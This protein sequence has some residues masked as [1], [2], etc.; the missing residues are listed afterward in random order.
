MFIIA[1]STSCMSKKK[2]RYQ[3]V[4]SGQ[5]IPLFGATLAIHLAT[6]KLLGDKIDAP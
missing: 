6:L 3:K 4:G 5:G 2:I 1:L